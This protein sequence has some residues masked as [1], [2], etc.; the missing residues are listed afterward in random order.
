ME[1][2]LVCARRWLDQASVGSKIS[3]MVSHKKG[4]IPLLDKERMMGVADTL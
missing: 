2:F 1:E 3:Y 4:I